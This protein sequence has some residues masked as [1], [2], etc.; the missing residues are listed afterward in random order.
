[1]LSAAI[2]VEADG[3]A[4]IPRQA[5]PLAI[6]QNRADGGAI[7]GEKAA[8]DRQ[9]RLLARRQTR[10]TLALQHV[11]ARL[12]AHAPAVARIEA[13]RP[14]LHRSVPGSLA[15]FGQHQTA[16]VVGRLLLEQTLRVN[17]DARRIAQREPRKRRRVVQLHGEFRFPVARIEFACRSP[18]NL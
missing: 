1:M 12:D 3:G 7:V 11:A 16:L 8:V 13:R 10:R 2:F 5:A 14:H 4:A 6:N 18:D 17:D 15:D 9:H